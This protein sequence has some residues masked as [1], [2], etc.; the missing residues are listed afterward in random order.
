MWIEGLRTIIERIAASLPEGFWLQ[1]PFAIRALVMAILVAIACG[2]VGGLVVGSRMAFFSD[3]L[4]HCAFAG[5]T[6]G[7]LLS[8]AG[9]D[10][11]RDQWMVPLV[12]VVFGIIVGVAIAFV[13]ENTSL[14][15]DTVIGVF[16]AFAVGFGG[17][18]LSTL[19][20]STFLDPEKFLFG[21]ILFVTETDILVLSLMLVFL[22]GVL[23]WSY[24]FIVFSS[25]SPSL[26]RSR[27]IKVR[28]LNFLFIALLALIVNLCLRA[29]G[30]LLINAMLVVP[31]ATAAN[32][33]RSA[34]GMF[35]WTMLAALSASIGGLWISSTVSI[36]VG[37]GDPIQLGPSGTIVVLS[38][39]MFFCS[40]T[41]RILRDR[42]A[43]AAAT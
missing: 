37:R 11:E 13:R 42:R 28:L 17:M 30:A 9:N 7:M 23:A 38:V 19:R 39:V 22:A 4:A 1:A 36:P 15:S 26:A 21:S 12:M 6:L 20:R 43:P 2:S 5:V 35:W 41:M 8:L 14:A 34:R 29:V 33:G 18:L 10:P 27:G 40:L 31:A 32:L 25:F 24:N 3:A 16:F